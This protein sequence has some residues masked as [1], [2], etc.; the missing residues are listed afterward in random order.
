[1]D[2]LAFDTCSDPSQYNPTTHTPKQQQNDHVNIKS[3]D[4]F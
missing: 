4:G 1:M 3:T 2:W